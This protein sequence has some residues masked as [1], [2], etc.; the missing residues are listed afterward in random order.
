VS[1]AAGWSFTAD[2][3]VSYSFDQAHVNKMSPTSGGFAAYDHRTTTDVSGAKVMLIAPFHVGVGYEDYTVRDTTTVGAPG[4]PCIGVC[5]GT[6]TMKVRMVDVMLDIPMHYLNLGVGYGQGEADVDIFLPAIVNS[7]VA[8]IRHAAV[9]QAFL[10]LGIP[11]G[12]RW[13]L[14]LGYHWVQ[15]EEKDVI[16][17]AN[18]IPDKLQAGGQMLSAG[19]RLNF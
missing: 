1:H 15:V 5:N 2:S 11:L 16:G 12:M 7:V 8:P 18:P 3:P 13:D 17:G 6:F 9:T 10:T 19:L 4:G 14:H